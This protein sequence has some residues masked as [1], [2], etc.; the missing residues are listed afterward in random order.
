VLR[1]IEVYLRLRHNQLEQIGLIEERALL[2]SRHGK[3]LSSFAIATAFTPFHAV[4]TFPES[5]PRTLASRA[6][7]GRLREE[8]ESWERHGRFQSG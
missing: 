7:H 6:S 1:N 8:W 5:P 3:R 2:I 4:H